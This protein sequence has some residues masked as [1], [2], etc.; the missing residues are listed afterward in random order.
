[1]QPSSE[2][3]DHNDQW[4]GITSPAERR[5]RQNRLNQRAY[6]K[7]RHQQACRLLLEGA[8][9]ASETQ[10][11]I[12]RDRHVP[13]AGSL[14]WL[15]EPGWSNSW[16]LLAFK[17]QI[18][19]NYSLHLPVPSDLQTTARLN[20]IMAIASNA[21]ALSIP[22]AHLEQDE[23]VSP[24]NL[25]GPSRPGCAEPD[26]TAMKNLRPTP[27]QRSVV[28]HPWVD[29]F[30]IPAIR[31]NIIRGLCDASI[32]EDELCG[33]LFNADDD[34]DDAVSPMMLWADPSDAASWEF[35]TGFLRKWGRLLDG[36]P[37]VVEATNTWRRR[38][39]K[40]EIRFMCTQEDTCPRTNK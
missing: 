39:G 22:F 5:K 37:E 40:M 21:I 32:D 18:F 30:P 10:L 8:S 38:R 11:Q 34:G 3:W 23:S 15:R 14:S 1:M 35:S 9:A 13:D 2:V 4:A 16:R 33:A 29:L 17:E 31:D 26:L 12:T 24:F 20:V 6:R 36:C 27:L 28:H 19:M 7:K 25:Y